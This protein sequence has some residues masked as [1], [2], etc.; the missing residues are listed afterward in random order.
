MNSALGDDINMRMIEK[1]VRELMPASHND[2]P[3]L[4]LLPARLIELQGDDCLRIV[5]TSRLPEQERRY[6]ALS[7]VWGPDQTFVLL[8]SNQL[9]FGKGLEVEQ[10]PQTIR[11]AMTVARRIGFKYLWVDAL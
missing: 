2:K 7:Y 3:N 6:V 4:S 9:M 1:W 8:R 5:H 11:D 10:L